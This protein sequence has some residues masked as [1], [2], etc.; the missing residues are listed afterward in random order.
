MNMTWKQKLSLL[1]VWI[2]MGDLV[3]GVALNIQSAVLPYRAAVVAQGDVPVSPEIAFNWLQ[4]LVNG[5]MVAMILSAIAILLRMKRLSDA[6]VCL[7]PNLT[8]AIAVL[9]VL[10]FAAPAVWLWAWA[11]VDLLAHGRLTVA[12]NEPRYLLVAVCQPYLVWVAAMVW[13]KQHRLYHGIRNDTIQVP[14]Y[15]KF[16][17]KKSAD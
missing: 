15:Q 1:P 14:F 5:G 9:T 11:A 12:L 8:H 2:V 7:T 13:C 17:R 4:V 10:A 16:W 3:L 6:G